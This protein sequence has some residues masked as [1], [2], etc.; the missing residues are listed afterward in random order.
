MKNRLQKSPVLLVVDDVPEYLRSLEVVLRAHFLIA[1][2]SS[3]KRAQDAFQEHRPD[4]A[5]I[6]VR[7]DEAVPNDR[8]GLDLVRWLKAQSPELPVVVMSAVEDVS[9]PEHAK[10]AGADAFLK[11]PINLAELRQLL[12]SLIG[13]RAKRSG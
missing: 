7:L 8:S 13:Q 10:K 2:A 9:L 12:N 1:A 4:A 6:D 3:P 5:L 11:K